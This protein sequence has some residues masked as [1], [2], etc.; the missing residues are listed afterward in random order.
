MNT[1][2]RNWWLL[3][4]YYCSGR[5]RPLPYNALYM[6][7]RS[8]YDIYRIIINVFFLFKK[9]KSYR[10]SAPKQGSQTGRRKETNYH[11][12]M[13]RKYLL[14]LDLNL[15][16]AYVSGKTSEGRSFQRTEVEGMNDL[17][18]RSIL[19]WVRATA[20]WCAWE[21]CLVALDLLS[22][23]GMQLCSSTEHLPK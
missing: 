7:L 21:A 11:Y 17:E 3:T 10:C 2:T 15:V 19:L 1:I 20:Y 13:E 23:G 5:I 18:K 4:L 6:T 9:P 14:I 16:R 12:G 22:G 8:Y